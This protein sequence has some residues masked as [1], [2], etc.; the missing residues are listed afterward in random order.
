MSSSKASECLKILIEADK[1][2]QLIK[3]R[4]RTNECASSQRW[5]Y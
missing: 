5:N 1:K 3:M 2:M 4:K